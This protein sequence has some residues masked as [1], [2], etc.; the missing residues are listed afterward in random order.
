MQ[1]GD[2]TCNSRSRVMECI[3]WSGCAPPT[4]PA[5]LMVTPLSNHKDFSP[6]VTLHSPAVTVF[7]Q[8]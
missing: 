6:S 4:F 7:S 2:C 5:P 3:L 8:L 1:G